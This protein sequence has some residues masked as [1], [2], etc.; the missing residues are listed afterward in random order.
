MFKGKKILILI[1]I[2][3]EWKHKTITLKTLHAEKKQGD[4]RSECEWTKRQLKS[5]IND[6]LINNGDQWE[7]KRERE[8]L[9]INEGGEAWGLWEAETRE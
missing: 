5:D 1:H 2:W 7:R 9:P 8:S 3:F 4:M 6:L